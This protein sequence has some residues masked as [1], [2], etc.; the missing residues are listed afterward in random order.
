MAFYYIWCAKQ[1]V[2]DMSP[3]EKKWEESKNIMIL[4]LHSMMCKSE[5]KFE[6]KKEL[7]HFRSLSRQHDGDTLLRGL[8]DDDES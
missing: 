8:F 7:D 4:A 6:Y 5:F 3:E 2:N 1:N